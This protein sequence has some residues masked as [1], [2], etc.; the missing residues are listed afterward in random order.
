MNADA[1]PHATPTEGGAGGLVLLDEGAQLAGRPARGRE[2]GLTKGR[3]A[4]RSTSRIDG[5][6]AV[7]PNAAD[8]VEPLRRHLVDSPKHDGV[9]VRGVLGMRG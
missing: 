9:L 2:P 3:I 7:A 8:K 5:V 6:L 1:P 4:Q